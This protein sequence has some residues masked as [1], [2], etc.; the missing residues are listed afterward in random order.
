MKNT[1]ILKSKIINSKDELDKLLKNIKDSRKSIVFSNGCFDLIHKGHID[2][3]SKSSDI[4]DVLIVGINS[5]DSVRRLK[6]SS[7][8]LQK[9][10]SRA[11][12]MASLFF[13]DYVVPFN[14]DTPYNLINC[15]VP[16]FLVKGDD[17]KPE[18]I[19]GYDIVSKA[20]GKVV[21]I[22]LTEGYST[23]AIE[24]LIKEG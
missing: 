22:E 8:P 10:E 18:D 7:R 4:A 2:Y 13:V 12:I 21:T 1:D 11:N 15:I 19:V 16:D 5:D 14:E 3:L 6:G 20:G 9:L 17:Y 24:K 23:S